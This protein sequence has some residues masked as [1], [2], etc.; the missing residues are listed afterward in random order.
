MRAAGLNLVLKGAAANKINTKMVQLEI[1]KAEFDQVLVDAE[2]PPPCCACM[3][4]RPA[5]SE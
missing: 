2:E 5:G 1:R 3:F 4:E